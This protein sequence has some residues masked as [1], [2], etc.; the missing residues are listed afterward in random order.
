MAR[1]SRSCGGITRPGDLPSHHHQLVPQ[2]RDF[3]V[4]AVRGWTQPDQPEERR[5]ITNASVRTIMTLSLP[6]PGFPDQRVVSEVAPAPPAS[7][8]VPEP[9]ELAAAQVGK[10]LL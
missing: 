1:T 2:H 10:V 3:D 5:T 7:A 4:L 9:G 8:W 6:E